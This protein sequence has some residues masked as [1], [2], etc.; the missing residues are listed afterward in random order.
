MP[1]TYDPFV[2]PEPVYE[3]LPAYE[4]TFPTC[5]A[6]TSQPACA[7]D[8]PTLMCSTSPG[9]VDKLCCETAN[10]GSYVEANCLTQTCKPVPDCAVGVTCTSGDSSVCSDCP[11]DHYHVDNGVAHDE[12]LP[13]KRQTGCDAQGIDGAVCFTV[14]GEIEGDAGALESLSEYLTCSDPLDGFYI[15]EIGR[16]SCRERV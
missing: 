2:S 16:A 1:P 12:C 3:C 15:K 13:C 10:A 14:S 5:T 9:F 6:C 8:F 4:K 11:D 7:T